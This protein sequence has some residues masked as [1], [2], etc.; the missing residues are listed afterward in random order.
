MKV[1]AP[2]KFLLNH[3]RRHEAAYDF[4]KRL[5]FQLNVVFFNRDGKQCKTLKI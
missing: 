1:D 5:S 4:S 2:E 3:I